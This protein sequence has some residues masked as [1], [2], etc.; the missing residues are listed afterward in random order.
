MT[1]SPLQERDLISRAQS[2]DQFA[3]EEIIKIYSP[4]LYPVI[5][6]FTSDKL[7]IEAGMQET[8]WRVWR[9]LDHYKFDKPFLP[10][11]V[12]IAANYQRDLWRKEKKTVNIDLLELDLPDENPL[13]VEIIENSDQ[14]KALTQAIET[15][16][17]H[18]RLVI[19]LHYDAGMSYAE[20]AQSLGIPINTIR[21]HLRRAKNQIRKLIGEFDG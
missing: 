1:L 21:T 19:A 15:L 8:F 10:Y 4:L 7:Q 5:R 13:P 9:A 17:E 12:T 18:Y 20:I 11:L 3:F 16:P 2:G 14:L 6:R